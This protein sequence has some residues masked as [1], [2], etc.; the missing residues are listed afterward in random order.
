V[1]SPN[2]VITTASEAAA[3]DQ[4]THLAELLRKRL[5][6]FTTMLP[7][8]LNEEDADAVHDL[9]VLSRRLQQVL[10]TLFAKPRPQEARD[11]IRALRRARRAIGGWRDCDVLAGLLAQ[12]TRR[13][14]N[15]D[16]RRAWELV[17]ASV[18]RRRRREMRRA[19]RR[20]AN[21]RLFTIAQT[22]QRLVERAGGQGAA[23]GG[24]Q[25]SDPTPA[26]A[27]SVSAAYSQ[28]G[29]ALG[30]ARE[31]RQPRDI[32]ALRIETK[33]LRYR[34]ELVHDLGADD[35]EPALRR[36]KSIQDRLGRWR[37]RGELGRMTAEALADA[38]FL[39]REPRVASAMLRKLARQQKTED[40][41]TH[42]LLAA[43][44]EAADSSD[45]GAWVTEYCDARL[46]LEPHPPGRTGV[47]S[48]PQ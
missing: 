28:W 33:R 45:L 48:R 25:P 8:V 30:R 12:K 43:A 17:L 37:D 1:S 44:S 16:E 24:A 2:T 34:I 19:R 35:S 3:T 21:R 39:L 36:L 6:R 32:H 11:M 42:E 47:D 31:T 15:P 4:W 40:E 38:R 26:L 14:R 13:V 23:D 27:A 20:L 46:R 18:A 9:R 22:G 10:A 7:K 41:E 5:R 29:A